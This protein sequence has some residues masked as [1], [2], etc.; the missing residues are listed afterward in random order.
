MVKYV[1]PYH[2]VENFELFG[3]KKLFDFEKMRDN[4]LLYL[5]AQRADFFELIGQRGV[6]GLGDRDQIGECLLLESQL[7]TMLIHVAEEPFAGRFDLSALLRTEIKPV[8]QSAMPAM[9]PLFAFVKT[10]PEG[11][12]SEGCSEPGVER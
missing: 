5:V 7:A 10:M 2:L 4:A 1:P 8:V 11:A 9:L 3:V 12:D 6:I